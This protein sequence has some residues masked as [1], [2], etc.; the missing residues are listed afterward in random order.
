MDQNFSL[1]LSQVDANDGL[2][3][4]DHNVAVENIELKANKANNGQMIK[5]T[6][7]VLDG[8]QSGRKQFE[9]YNVSNPNP[10]AVEIGTRNLKRLLMAAFNAPESQ[11]NQVTLQDIQSAKD[12]RL[13]LTIGTNK[14]GDTVIKK[15]RPFDGAGMT[16]NSYQQQQNGGNQGAQNGQYN[17]QSGQNA[18]Q[19]HQQ[20]APANNGGGRPWEQ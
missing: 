2:S 20:T 4:G 14:S 11:F 16:T 7:V 8:P 17:Q 15:Y 18:P 10:Q 13:T 19:N 12:Q 5:A 9:N 6:F 3:N 1:D